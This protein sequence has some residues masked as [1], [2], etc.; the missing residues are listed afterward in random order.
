[1][2]DFVYISG[3]VYSEPRHIQNQRHIQNPG[4]FC[5]NSSLTIWNK[6]YD[7]FKYCCNF[8]NKVIICW[9]SCVPCS[10]WWLCSI[11]KRTCGQVLVLPSRRLVRPAT[12]HDFVILPQWYLYFVK[13]VWKPR[14]LGPCILIYPKIAWNIKQ[15]LII[16]ETKTS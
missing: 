3:K 14:G 6:Y 10:W 4:A 13:K 12:N 2:T 11:S 1:M 7:L 9:T 5:K 16:S 15:I 8:Y